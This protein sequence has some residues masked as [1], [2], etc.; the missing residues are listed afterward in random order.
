MHRLVTLNRTPSGR[1]RA[2]AQ[3]WLDPAL[4]ETVVLLY[5]VVHIL[6]RPSLA[7]F[8]QQIFLLQVTDGTN[9]GRILVNIDDARRGDI[10][11]TQHLAE[12][13]FGG[14]STSGLV[15]KE[16]ERLSC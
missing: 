9:V 3:P 7:L 16:I 5:N 10:W 2:E 15:E 12:E 14:T 13:A 8:G 4:H 1:V 11:S 6:T